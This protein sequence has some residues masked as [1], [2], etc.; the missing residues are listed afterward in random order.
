MSTTCPDDD[1]LAALSEG[2]LDADSRAET[3]RHLDECEECRV[4]VGQLADLSVLDATV[5]EGALS[6]QPLDAPTPLGGAAALLPRDTELGKY[7]VVQPIGAGGM[8]SVYEAHDRDLDRHVA[9]KML[10]GE[11]GASQ[12]YRARLRAEAK[13][14]A[15]LN[16]PNVVTIYEVGTSKSQ[17]YIAME[18]VDGQTVGEWLRAAD[19]SWREVVD[20]FLAAGRGLAAAHAAG[21]VHRD[22]KPSNILMGDDGRVRVTDFGL[23]RDVDNARELPVDLDGD[24]D[25]AQPALTQTGVIIGTPN[26][27]APEQHTAAP[28]DARTDQFGFCVALWEGLFGERPFD[29]R[30]TAELRRAVT[31][32]EVKEPPA[33][34]NVPNRVRRIVERG[35]SSE[36]DRRSE[37]MEELLEDLARDPSRRKKSVIIGATAVA[38][39][40]IGFG[41]ATAFMSKG[42][43]DDACTD[44]RANLDGVWDGDRRGAV[45]DAFELTGRPYAASTY[46][47]VAASLDEYAEAWTLA[48]GD[49]C[50]RSKKKQQS[51]AM[52]DL[53]MSCLQTRLDGL[54]ALTDQFAAPTEDTIN[55]AVSATAGLDGIDACNDI[56]GLAAAYEPPPEGIRAAVAE[57][58]TALAGAQVQYDL[59][60][61]EDGLKVAA[62][63]LTTA[64]ELDYPPLVAKAMLLVGELTEQ[65]GDPLGALTLLEEATNAAARARDDRLAADVWIT[66]I[67]IM[68]NASRANEALE[69]ATPAEVAVVR[70][71][72]TPPQ[73]AAWHYALG[74]S[75]AAGGRFAEAFDHHS[76]AIAV[77]RTTMTGD[78][79]EIARGLDALGVSAMNLG[80]YEES[81]K[82]HE[83]ALAM[84][85]RVVGPQ[86]PNVGKILLNLG[87]AL[88]KQGDP[89]GA[90]RRFE[91][92]IELWE[93][94]IGPDYL[95]IASA[96]NNLALVRE[97]ELKFDIALA[98]YERAITLVEGAFG[99]DTAKIGPMLT[100][101]AVL[102]SS[103]GDM[104]KAA[105]VNRRVLAIEIE[106]LGDDHPYVGNDHNNLG[107][108]LYRLEEYDEAEK[109]FR[110]AIEIWVV[111][112]GDDHPSLAFALTGL[113]V[114]LAAQ[115]R[116]SEAIELFERA[117]AIRT[118]KKVEPRVLA[119]SQFT[120]AMALWESGGDKKR[121]LKL[122]DEALANFRAGEVH[123][124]VEA[125]QQWQAQARAGR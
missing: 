96:L 85:E 65:T 63:V 108:T 36:R 117:I 110:R 66:R 106:A 76:K 43:G 94:N 35:L 72:D 116:Y 48:Y 47:L 26:Y 88:R 124:Q 101:I 111:K 93:K 64:R 79:I 24:T 100:N 28:A 90:A 87:V 27:M 83:E 15:K 20:V 70:A 52:S 23:A 112:L 107:D 62:D 114:T 6:T 105:E 39:V 82:L 4:V 25:P 91:E 60:K 49:S 10:R 122:S 18:L 68:A 42:G 84:I 29:G 16:H 45:R 19:R 14:L 7:V 5:A 31:S 98:H 92:A 56:K 109:H 3:E 113:G 123:G 55:R 53:R 8:G 121:A 9:I 22:V 69:W 32:G 33:S 41:G 74:V 97:L 115:E 125:V 73:R 89:N 99:K 103:Q 59:G 13:A 37:S 12:R 71:G 21:L 77:R 54:R 57:A 44:P 120:L 2:L 40:A 119:R 104:H 30:T 58:T 67:H 38:L 11:H 17:D 46:E 75:Y 1:H 118:A 80:N 34:S 51:D 81:Q 61:Y 78:H 95:P 50:K 102:H 86:H